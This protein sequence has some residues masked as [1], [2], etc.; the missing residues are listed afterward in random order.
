MIMEI[1][2]DPVKG[3][4]HRKTGEILV[5]LGIISQE[6]VQVALAEQQRTGEKLG[7]LMAR[8]AMLSEQR[9]HE[10]L[11]F[12]QEI[13]LLKLCSMKIDPAAVQLLAPSIIRF[14]KI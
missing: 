1:S 14:N 8:R 6:Q 4:R 5:S 13:P 9:L 11:D 10:T 2:S 3:S 12:S 7:Q